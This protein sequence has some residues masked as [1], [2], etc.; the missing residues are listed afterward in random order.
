M[1]QGYLFFR[2]GATGRPYLV[3]I[4]DKT[5]GDK[6]LFVFFKLFA[7]KYGLLKYREVVYIPIEFTKRDKLQ[8]L[9]VYRVIIPY[10]AFLEKPYLDE[11]CASFGQNTSFG[12]KGIYLVGEGQRSYFLRRYRPNGKPFPVR[13]RISKR[14]I[15]KFEIYNETKHQTLHFDEASK[16]YDLLDFRQGAWKGDT[17]E[18]IRVEEKEKI[19]SEVL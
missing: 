1:R 12:H 10:C 16:L 9:K 4:T 14:G 6:G 5:T 15:R 2:R 8:E 17:L 18:L 7:S 19:Y 11:D 13:Q 3:K